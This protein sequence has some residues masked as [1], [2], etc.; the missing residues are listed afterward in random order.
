MS[1]ELI[2]LSYIY[3]LPDSLLIWHISAWVT[4]FTKFSIQNLESICSLVGLQHI[5]DGIVAME[6]IFVSH[7]K[8]HFIHAWP[9]STKPEVNQKMGHRGPFILL[10][11]NIFHICHVLTIFMIIRELPYLQCMQASESQAGLLPAY[12]SQQKENCN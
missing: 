8:H 5:K 12:L 1:G 10:V 7:K 6:Q 3:Q 4:I 9:G 11:H 2:Q